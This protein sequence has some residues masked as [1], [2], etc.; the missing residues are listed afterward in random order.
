MKLKHFNLGFG[1]QIFKSFSDESRTRILHLL[2]NVGELTISDLVSILDYTQTKTSRH[3][4]FLRNAGMVSSRQQDQWVFYSIR[5]EG[6]HIVKQ[7]FNFLEKDAVLQKDLKT[8][9]TLRSNRELAINKLA[10]KEYRR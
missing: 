4:T 9:E 10:A 7:I 2:F 6:Y 3:M 5:E 8:C 1:M